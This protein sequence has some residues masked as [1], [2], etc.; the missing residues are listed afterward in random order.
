MRELK[1]VTSTDFDGN[2]KIEAK[3]GDVMVIS[4]IGFKTQ[5]ITVGTQKTINVNLEEEA[6]DLKKLSL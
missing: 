4:F 5:S 2:F 3:A 1:S 6:A